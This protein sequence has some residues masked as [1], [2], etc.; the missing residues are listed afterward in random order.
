MVL[1]EC[2]TVVFYIILS[3]Q[4]FEGYK[5]SENVA[6]SDCIYIVLVAMLINIIS[7][8]MSS[9]IQVIQWCKNKKHEKII[10]LDLN[11]ELKGSRIE[12]KVKQTE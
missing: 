7:S 1:N 5:I 4:F 9:I 10:P 11:N 8:V 12:T 3:M 6:A 2:L